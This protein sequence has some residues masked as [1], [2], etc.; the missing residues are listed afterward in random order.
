M[1]TLGVVSLFAPALQSKRPDRWLELRSPH[2]VVVSNA[3]EEETR[4]VLWDLERA[5]SVFRRVL[6]DARIDSHRP[7]V[8]LAVK[9]EDG[10]REVIPQFWEKKSQRPAA[11]YWPGPQH[12]RVVLRVDT[13]PRERA[14]HV[15]HEYGH[16]LTRLNI[17]DAPAWLDEGLAELWGTAVI[18]GGTTEVGRPAAHHLKVLRSRR[19]WIPLVDLVA[20]TRA[21]D[22]REST[23]L[24]LFYAQS[25]ALAH[26]LVLGGC[27]DRAGAPANLQLAPPRYV[28]RLRQGADPVE[29][30][31]LA[32]GDLAAIEEALSEYVRAARFRALRFEVSSSP[33]EAGHFVLKTLSPAEAL[34]VR[35]GFLLDGERPAAALPLLAEA[36]ALEPNAAPALE[37]LG[38]FYFQQNNPTEAAKWFD[39]AIESES[40]SYVAHYYK[41]ILTRTIR[42]ASDGREARG[43]GQGV[44]SEEDHLRR[45]IALDA[46]FAPAYAS[47][48]GLLT[49]RRR[50]AEGERETAGGRLGEAVELAR[51]ATE[52]EPANAAYANLLRELLEQESGR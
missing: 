2:F 44:L 35:A 40:P 33:A 19:P 39:R 16:L 36:V 8:V 5:R 46:T 9:D 10:L 37:T 4:S 12:H 22:P 34:S 20:M 49:G 30:A 13:S 51:R 15:I 17:P 43:E 50:E 29:A 48:A 1:V 26:C 45:A 11:A 21:P 25:W 3:G 41:A 7:P 24:S 32:F 27:L 23:R 52:L 18:E 47:L 28:E 6:T 14:R 38:R 42:G 31:R